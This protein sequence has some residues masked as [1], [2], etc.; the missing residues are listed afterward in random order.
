M[1]QDQ[2][3][4]DFN[5][6]IIQRIYALIKSDPAY[7]PRPFREGTLPIDK[8]LEAIS[9]TTSMYIGSGM[10]DK[11]G[12]VFLEQFP[13]SEA[14]LIADTNTFQ[15]QGSKL[16][17]SLMASGITI[18]KRLVLEASGLRPD[19]DLV[20]SLFSELK[21]MPS[22][23]IPIAIGAG[24]IND[25]VKLAA[26]LAGKKYMC[27]PTA[28]S[29]DGYTAYGA[30]IWTNGIKQMYPCSGPKAV[31]ADMDIIEQAPYEMTQA[32]FAD[33]ISKMTAGADWILS[34]W[35]GMGQ[36]NEKAWKISQSGFQEALLVADRFNPINLRSHTKKIFE[37]LI[38][39]GFAM[40]VA[41]SDIPA[42]GAAHQICDIWQLEHLMKD[43]KPVSYGSL[44]SIALQVVT[45][46]YNKLLI[47][48]FEEYDMERYVRQWP[49]FEEY[50]ERARKA[51]SK[52][53][54]HDIGLQRAKAKYVT[55]EELSL[56]LQQLKEY[57]PDIRDRLSQQIKPLSEL[58]GLLKN[59]GLPISPDEIGISCEHLKQTVECVSYISKHFTILDL[60]AR[61]DQTDINESFY[62]NKFYQ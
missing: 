48:P 24:T 17:E 6:D 1:H 8:A 15:I 20:T 34:D 43:G 25:V 61:T 36:I 62:L 50:E 32:G 56:Q 33:L 3:S 18:E 14:V 51:I 58:R 11:A 22:S 19:Y 26:H 10:T 39:C 27:V 45:A 23:A 49:S 16:E 60:M 2:F 30:S 59:A 47:L 42:F 37:G 52:A 53:R 41:H 35:M 57:W 31:L 38:L 4:S 21:A 46:L 7:Q 54:I 40:Q 5:P 44:L 29:M 28:A 9:D 13:S 55:R 12:S